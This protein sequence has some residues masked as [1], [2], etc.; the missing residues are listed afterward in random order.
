MRIPNR[1]F[2]IRDFF[3]LKLGIRDSKAKL[4]RDSGLKVCVGGWMS[5]I[6]IG[7]TGLNEIF[8]RDYG[9]EEHYC[10]PV[11]RVTNVCQILRVTQTFGYFLLDT[12]SMASLL[13]LNVF[14]SVLIIILSFC[15][16]TFF[17]WFVSKLIGTSAVSSG[18]ELSSPDQVSPES[19]RCLYT[20]ANCS[21][22]W[23]SCLWIIIIIMIIVIIIMII[24]IMMMMIIIIIKTLLIRQKPSLHAV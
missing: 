16:W 1:F 14:F 2:G 3:Y 23:D 18:G 4:G 6:T 15:F 7:I 17:R 11:Q 22:S 21:M 8:S 19:V 24:I 5:N 9:I 12:L 10:P 13:T 20:H